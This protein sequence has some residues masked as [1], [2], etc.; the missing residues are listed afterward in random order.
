MEIKDLIIIG[1]GPGGVT[2][3]IYA[4]RAGLNVSIFEKNIVGGAVINAFEIE[5]YPGVGKIVGSDLA[6][7]LMNEVDNFGIDVHYD[8][9]VSLKKEDGI[10]HLVTAENE[11]FYSKKVLLALGTKPRKLGVPEEE[12]LFGRGISYCATCDGA[13][14][15]GKDVLV[16]GGGNSALT[17]A[18][19]LTKIC[20]TV[21]LIT[22]H[23]LKGDKKEID[24]FLSKPNAK[25]IEFKQVKNIEYNPKVTGVTLFDTNTNEAMHLDVEG[26][27]VYVGQIPQTSFV[28]DLGVLNERGYIVVDS[29]YETSVSGLFAIGDC[30]DKAVRQIATAVGDAATAIHFIEE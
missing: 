15:K 21:Y 14:Y 3:A 29:K 11:N 20:R 22:R 7:N 6:M 23:E 25:S 8:E 17:E 2:A 13:F 12:M 28:K 4:T 24:N 19:Y 27:F 1:A 18:T 9:I 16:V 10:F 30:I 26:I 5:N